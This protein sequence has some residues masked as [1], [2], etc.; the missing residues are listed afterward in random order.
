M[1]RG[2]N[3]HRRVLVWVKGWYVKSRAAQSWFQRCVDWFSLLRGSEF[4]RAQNQGSSVSHA[5]SGREMH[6]ALEHAHAW[7]SGCT[8]ARPIKT[9][10]SCC[11]PPDPA[12]TSISILLLSC[13]SLF[14]LSLCFLLSHAP[15]SSNPQEAIHF[16][17]ICT[18][19]RG[20]HGDADH[21]SSPPPL[22]CG[23]IAQQQLP[24]IGAVG[25]NC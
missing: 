12:T 22:C 3:L 23:A 19:N 8:V 24:L 2:T 13:S 7:G 4:R 17:I 1:F 25:S 5:T 15:S 11:T 20:R 6:P 18:S 10:S 9:S 14:S 16:L 21:K